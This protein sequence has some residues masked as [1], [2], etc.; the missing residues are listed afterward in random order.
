M[1]RKAGALAL[2]VVGVAA[3]GAGCRGKSARQQAIPAPGKLIDVEGT[4][5]HLHVAGEGSA[6]PTVVLEAGM[7]SMSSNWG[8]VRRSLASDGLVVTYD[9]AG[10]GWSDPA[11]VPV[12][13]ASSAEMLHAALVS[14]HVAPPYVLAGHSYGGMV[15]RMYAD[16][17]PDE[18]M[19]MVLVDSSHPDQWAN[20]P[21]SF[22]GRTVA[23]GNCVS[24]VLASVGVLRLAHAERSFI[25]GLPP[26]EYAEMQAYLARPQGWLAG[27]RGCSP[28]PGRPALR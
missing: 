15:T 19:G 23:L 3:A 9:R 28:G 4:R 17:F 22:G 5:L 18:V 1:R 11:W 10:L 2:A 12:D 16:L 7:A 6:A 27:A 20:I 21:A 14:A 8:W 25:E 26:Q 13:A 24:A